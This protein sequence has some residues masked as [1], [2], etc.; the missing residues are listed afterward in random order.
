M[1]IDTLKL[2]PVR[3]R[4]YRRNKSLE[5]RLAECCRIARERAQQVRAAKAPA[6]HQ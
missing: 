1:L 4:R 3:V 6:A 2:K 5:W